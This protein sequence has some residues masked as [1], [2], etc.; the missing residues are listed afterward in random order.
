M[1]HA[2]KITLIAIATVL[3]GLVTVPAFM[4]PVDAA[5]I[6]ESEVRAQVAIGD[7]FYIDA[8]GEIFILNEDMESRAL[9]KMHFEFTIVRNG[10]R[11]V[12]FE[13]NSGYM[14][15]NNTRYTVVDGIGFAGRPSQ[16]RFNSTIVFGFRMNLTDGLGTEIQLS[17]LGAVYRNANERPVLIMR[18]NLILNGLEYNLLQRGLIRRM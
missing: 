17:F 6:L 8:R 14:V 4:T 11:G 9:T 3:I 18:G 1:Q 15:V 2:R 5:S 7:S 12:M 16:G 13:V 10:S